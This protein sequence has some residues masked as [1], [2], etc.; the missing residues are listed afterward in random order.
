M[1]ESKHNNLFAF[2]SEVNGI[3]KSPPQT[4]PEF[5]IHLWVK[6]WI[7]YNLTSAGIKHPEK[8]LA[9][10]GSLL[11]IPGITG[12]DIFLQCGKET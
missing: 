3:R 12:N 11:F 2:Y 10:A 4:T 1:E 9:K 8:F 5:A 6:Q 7:P